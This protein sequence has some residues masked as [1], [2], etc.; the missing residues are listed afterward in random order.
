M[1]VLRCF[2]VRMRFMCVCV[3]TKALCLLRF[4]FGTHWHN[5]RCVHVHVVLVGVNAKCRTT[6]IT[7]TD[8]FRC[9]YIV[10]KVRSSE[11]GPNSAF[12]LYVRLLQLV[13]EMEMECECQCF[14]F[15]A[16][17]TLGVPMVWV[18]PVR[19]PPLRLFFG[20]V[21]DN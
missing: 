6:S 17:P 7:Y 10:S 11:L 21:F 20:F 8:L 9:K 14:R 16:L 18:R 2:L 4:A 3:F 12:N 5:A 1:C 19:S 15:H 13:L